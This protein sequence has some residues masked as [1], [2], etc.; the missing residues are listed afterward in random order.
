MTPTMLTRSPPATRHLLYR[1]RSDRRRNS[2]RH[3]VSLRIIT[4]GVAGAPV[5]P[6]EAPSVT[7]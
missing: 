5:F 4:T 6:R 1:R 2:M 3:E 7:S